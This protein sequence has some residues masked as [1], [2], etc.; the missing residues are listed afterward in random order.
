[1]GWNIMTRLLSIGGGR[2][3]DTPARR[4]GVFAIDIIGNQLS[5]VGVDNTNSPS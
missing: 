2:G 1:M 4:A 3:R 5:F